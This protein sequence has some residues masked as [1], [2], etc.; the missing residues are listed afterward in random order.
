MDRFMV[1]LKNSRYTPKDAETILSN[2][3]D[4]AYRMNLTIRDCSI[5]NKFI[6]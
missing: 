3:R 2:S 1:H 4:L 6:D 5:S